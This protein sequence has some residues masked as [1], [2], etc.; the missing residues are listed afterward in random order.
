MVRQHQTLRAFATGSFAT[1]LH[2]MARDPAM[3]WYLDGV[4]NHAGGIN[5]NFGRECLELFTLGRDAPY[6]QGDVV[7]MSRACSGWVFNWPGRPRLGRV[8]A[9]PF[10]SVLV[11][12]R[13][14]AG[15]KT[16]LGRTGEL[17][18]DAALD[19]VLARPETGRFVASKLFRELVGLEP[20]PATIEPIAAEFAR[21]YEILPLVRAIV[22]T[23]EFLSDAAVRSRVR[24]PVE[25]LVTL[26]QATGTPATAGT[27]TRRR[28]ARGG[29]R[30]SGALLALRSLGYVPFNPPN[31]GGYP[32]GARLLGP[33]QLVHGFDLLAAVG[34]ADVALLPTDAAGT[35]AR[36]GAF[37]VSARSRRVVDAARTPGARLALAFGAPEVV[38]A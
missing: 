21:D 25:R 32:K 9:P 17:D 12:A 34:E 27:L 22:S 20:A 16:L 15:A 19:V 8:P 33:H 18:L 26:L 3:L 4:S 6:T 30:G 2:A 1:L 7:A 38:L 23:P 36:F 14:D 11:R 5:E 24:S 31:V 28:L 35:F 10:E 37:D 29:G 13:H